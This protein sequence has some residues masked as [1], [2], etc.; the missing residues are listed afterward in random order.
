MLNL[1][2]SLCFDCAESIARSHVDRVEFMAGCCFGWVEN[3][4]TLWF[5]CADRSFSAG[6][7]LRCCI[8]RSSLRSG[9]I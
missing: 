9:L 5:D 3:V 1:S 2:P 8:Y 4:A 7:V 6:P